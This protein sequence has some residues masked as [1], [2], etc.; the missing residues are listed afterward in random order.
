MKKVFVIYSLPRSGTTLLY[1]LVSGSGKRIASPSELWLAPFSLHAGR[2]EFLSPLGGCLISQNMNRVYKNGIS[3]RLLIFLYESIFQDQNCELIFD[4]TPRNVHAYEVIK[5]IS[6]IKSAV[7]LRHPID[8]FI[9]YFEI[10]EDDRFNYFMAYI[11]LVE[12]FDRLSAIMKNE[13]Y[14]IFI[15]EDI[16][17]VDKE[18]ISSLIDFLG[19]HI[20]V[21]IDLDQRSDIGD[22]LFGE[23]YKLLSKKSSFSYYEKF[24]RKSL[25][26]Q[27]IILNLT[28]R[29]SVNYILNEFYGSEKIPCSLDINITSVIKTPVDIFFYAVSFLAVKFQIKSILW[30]G[31]DNSKAFLR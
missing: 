24:P 19:F 31:G 10:F 17:K 20:D 13:E 4:K 11:D 23:K 15:Y 8:I 2:V 14:P 9:S 1:N 3:E 6:T 5:K 29:K 18:S 7:F 30:K 25:L 28:K 27:K 12:G 16:C 21:N 22:S 26:R